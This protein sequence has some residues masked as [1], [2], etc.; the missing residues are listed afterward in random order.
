M[1]V[2]D[3]SV[4]ASRGVIL[5]LPYHGYVDEEKIDWLHVHPETVDALEV[6]VDEGL[7]A[8]NGSCFELLRDGWNWYVNLMYF[9][10]PLRER[11]AIDKNNCSSLV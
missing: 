1:G 8:K 11:R 10:A 9:L 5:H 6:L 7:V 3:R 2:H 4:D